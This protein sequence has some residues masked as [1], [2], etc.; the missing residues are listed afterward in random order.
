[1][2]VSIDTRSAENLGLFAWGG[3]LFRGGCEQSK[4]KSRLILFW[5]S[6][7]MSVL[8]SS[9]MRAQMSVASFDEG[10]VNDSTIAFISTWGRHTEESTVRL[11]LFVKTHGEASRRPGYKVSDDTDEVWGEYRLLDGSALAFRYSAADDFLEVCGERFDLQQGRVFLC[12]GMASL[13]QLRVNLR[14]LPPLGAP[15]RL[16]DEAGRL[17]EE[18]FTVG[19]FVDGTGK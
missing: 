5:G 9:C 14:P 12:G 11:I 10:Q 2:T 16:L 3:A 8:L 13:H 17:A 15:R 7:G 18:D 1:M 4:M 6:I 19:A